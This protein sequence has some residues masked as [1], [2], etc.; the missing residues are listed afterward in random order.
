M[1]ESIS[2]NFSESTLSQVKPVVVIFFT[3]YCPFCMEFSQIF[4]KYSKDSR[5]LFVKADITDDNN[6]FW[7]KYHIE[8]V[9][10]V[11]ILNEG[12]VKA[13]KDAVG[14]VG[15]TE[16]NLKDLLKKIN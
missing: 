5:Y 13:R 12:K 4:E 11:I 15:L 3:S 9:P 2:N 10:S 6:P 14:G 1:L 8:T 7:E 16:K